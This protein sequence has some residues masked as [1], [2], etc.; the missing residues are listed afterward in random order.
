MVILA[1]YVSMQHAK[2]P[3][4]EYIVNHNRDDSGNG[5]LMRLAP[6]PVFFCYHPIDIALNYA[7]ESSFTTHPGYIASEACAFMS[8]IIIIY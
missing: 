1:N 3:N 5:S 8:Y 6:I 7:R 4:K 2:I